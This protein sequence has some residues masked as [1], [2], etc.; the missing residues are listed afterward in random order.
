PDPHAVLAG[1]PLAGSPP[2]ACGN[3]PAS[4]YNCSR[5]R[6]REPELLQL[7]VPQALRPLPTPVPCP[8]RQARKFAGLKKYAWAGW[9][10]LPVPGA[11]GFGPPG[12]GHVSGPGSS[13]KESAMGRIL[14]VVLMTGLLPGGDAQ[15][16]TKQELDKLQ[17]L[18]ILASVETKGMQLPKDKIA[19]NV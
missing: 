16:E 4:H 19:K 13:F 2:L 8:K 3:R 5:R 15:K 1:V 11:G 18:W 6:L 17:G 7:V 10:K 12:K 14:L 9:R